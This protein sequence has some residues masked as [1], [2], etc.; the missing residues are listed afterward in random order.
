MIS[1]LFANRRLFV[2]LLSV[3]LLTVSVG[4]TRG[5]REEVT[6]VE[7][8][9]KNTHAWLSGW[10]QGP[11]RLV[12]G[13]FDGDTAAV[14][15]SD[16]GPENVLRLKAEVKRLKQENRRLKEAAGYIERDKKNVITARTVSRSPDRWNDRVVIDRGKVDG[17]RTDMPVVTDEGL[18]GRISAATDHM[19]DVQLLTDSGSAPGIAAH[20]RTGDEEIFGLLEGYDAKKK[21][22]LLKK[23]PSGAKLKKGQLV[24]TSGLSDIFPGDLLIGTV[25]EVKRGDF[26]VDRMVYVKPA[27]RFERLHYVMVV[28]DPAKIKL[29]EHRKK[30]NSEGEGNGV[31]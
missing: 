31:D 10:I 6:W 27:A 28:R 11:T 1:R 21:R 4:M 3:I 25:D 19:A 26:G 13:W 16:A 22:L 29:K 30:L 15:G 7:A 12:A 9:V 24:V 20:V 14:N 18:I 17:I 8:G 5:E 23:I 2:I